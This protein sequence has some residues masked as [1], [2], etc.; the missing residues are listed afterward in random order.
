MPN[1]EHW[2]E[3][4]TLPKCSA[5]QTKVYFEQANAFIK[6][7]KFYQSMKADA[8]CAVAEYIAY[9]EGYTLRDW[10]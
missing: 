3:T 1:N 7:T 10:K 2:P 5:E 4:R 8:A 9:Q 6:A